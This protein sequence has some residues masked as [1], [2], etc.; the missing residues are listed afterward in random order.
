MLLLFAEIPVFPMAK[1]PAK[2]I[3]CSELLVGAFLTMPPDTYASGPTHPALKTGAKDKLSSPEFPFALSAA[4]NP[5]VKKAPKSKP[6]PAWVT[7]G[8]AAQ[9]FCAARTNQLFAG[10]FEGLL[11]GQGP[12]VGQRI[13]PVSVVSRPSREKGFAPDPSLPFLSPQGP[14]TKSFPFQT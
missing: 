5:A 11:G 10:L 2:L 14:G 12:S 4:W 7:S 3:P 1:L 13:E 9:N 8:Y 6:A